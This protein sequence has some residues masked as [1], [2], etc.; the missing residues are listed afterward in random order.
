MI[1]RKVTV[2]LTDRETRLLAALADE[3]GVTRAE[4]MRVLLRG[5]ADTVDVW[6]PALDRIAAQVRRRDRIRALETELATLL[7]TVT[8]YH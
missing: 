6:T 4:M 2:R 1:E 5:Q 3:H 7:D 8:N